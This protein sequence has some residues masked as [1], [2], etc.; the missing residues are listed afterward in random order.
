MTDRTEEMRNLSLSGRN[1]NILAAGDKVHDLRPHLAEQL[2][3]RLAFARD[4]K[5]SK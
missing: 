1:Q 5:P 3:H 4:I 2:K